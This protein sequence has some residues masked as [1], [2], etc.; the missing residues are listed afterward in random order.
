[1]KTMIRLWLGMACALCA[2][3]SLAAGEIK[4]QKVQSIVATRNG[5]Q[6]QSVVFEANVANLAFAKQV[7]AHL[8]RGDGVWIDVPLY[9]SRSI[10]GSREIWAGSFSPPLNTTYDVNFTLKYVVNGLTY[11]DNNGGANF[12]IA[13]DSGNIVAT[14]INI[15]NGNYSAAV[16]LPASEPY[17]RGW[18]TARN[19]AFAKIV[20]IHYSTD[21]WAT[22]KLANGSFSSTFWASWSSAAPNPNPYGFEEWR[23]T[24]NIGT[25]ATQ[26]EYAIEYQVNGQTYW[27]NNYGQNY[28]TVITRY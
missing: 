26:V 10:P 16:S 15:Y 18:T 7:Y 17:F 19:L 23:F 28:R 24:L 22:S 11:W 13:K 12:F 8:R 5:Q 25:T 21:G 4:F 3:L 2:A 14:P 27:D 1:M 6:Q 9:Y 20:R